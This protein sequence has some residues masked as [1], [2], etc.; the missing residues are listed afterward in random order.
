M[1][2]LESELMSKKWW[3]YRLLTPD[4][5]TIAFIGSYAKRVP[6]YIERLGNCPYVNLLKSFEIVSPRKWNNWSIAEKTR[7]WCDERCL[8]YDDFWIMA[9]EEHEK[10]GWHKT[11]FNS[12]CGQKML[13]RIQNRLKD[14]QFIQFSRL[15]FFTDVGYIGCP[16]Q[17]KYHRFIVEKIGSKYGESAMEA[18]MSLMADGLLSKQYFLRGR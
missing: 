5:A 6:Q 9:C 3:D 4:D 8:S 16:L 10:M 7:M 18:I 17:I 14:R 2:P 13:E 1:I 11:F 12:F 15:G